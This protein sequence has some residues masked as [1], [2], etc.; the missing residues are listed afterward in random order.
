MIDFT[1][2]FETTHIYLRPLKREDLKEFSKI[3]SDKD[4]WI[5][6]TSDLSDKKALSQWVD[7]AVQDINSKKRLALTVIDKLNNKLI[8]STSLGN[9]SERDKR[10]EI[11]WT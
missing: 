4:L 2:T 8:G 9:N 7:S 5:Y 10:I 1:K 6:F 3:T 11:G